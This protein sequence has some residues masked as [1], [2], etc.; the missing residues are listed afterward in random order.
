[1]S[2]NQ[3]RSRLS[4]ELYSYISY[5]LLR[6][7]VT[8]SFRYF[9]N[10]LKKFDIFETIIL[11]SK[12][13]LLMS[14]KKYGGNPYFQRYLYK[15]FLNDYHREKVESFLKKERERSFLFHRHQLLFLL[16]NVFLYCGSLP[17]INFRIPAVKERL[18]KCCLLANDFLS[19]LKVRDE[20]LRDAGI[21]EKKE[22]LWKELLPSYEL[23][24]PSGLM[25]DIGRIRLFFK[26][27][28][29][30]LQDAKTYIDI[31]SKF[32][33]YSGYSLDDY[34]FF[35]FAILT[36]Y[37]IRRDEIIK[38]P[39]A[40]FIE[41]ENFTRHAKIQREDIVRFLDLLSIPY[42]QYKAEILDSKDL[43]LNYGFLPFR[44]YP[45]ARILQGKYICIDFNFILEKIS[46]GIFWMINDN[47]PKSERGKF[48]T[49]WGNIFESYLLH[50][51]EETELINKGIFIP[52]PLFDGSRDE[53]AD[54]MMDFG[55]DLI[56]F[57]FKFTI[58]TQ[59]SKYS[60]SKD[61]LVNE[62]KLKFEKNQKGEWKGYG[63]LANNINKL[64]S[65]DRGLA[66]KYINKE[67]VKRVYPILITY[68]H[69]FN[70]PFTNHFMNRYFQNLIDFSS[71]EERVEIKPLVIFTIEDFEAAQPFL[72][73]FPRLIQERLEYD[74][75][76]DISFSD[77]LR[78][79]Y[80]E[81]RSL[82][83]DI[84]EKEYVKYSEEMKKVFFR[85]KKRL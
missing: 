71:I 44:K 40:I 16:K 30:K 33:E 5:S 37:R 56:L 59:E 4:A 31:D 43:N 2:P 6:P 62:L 46:N 28:L 13:N 12:L 10:Q 18:G 29:P 73:E 8:P 70:A 45:L 34:M 26:K 19:L 64:F 63:Q 80:D 3:R 68:E 85:D 24:V 36:L 65:K 39:N 21:E 14:E 74:K 57:E 77:F 41:G 51:F 50:F 32:K 84:I 55:E 61:E 66:C 79:K 76:L 60:S 83:P 20:D 53:V 82:S 38:N 69:L 9:L 15:Y 81:D 35:I 7:E 42:E 72:K 27:V 49:F 47:L 58:L 67:K 54:G 78:R 75:E 52:K 48:H 25:F 1:M 11:L 22:V 23:S 17:N